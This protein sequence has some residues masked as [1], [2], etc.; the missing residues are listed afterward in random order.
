MK[1]WILYGSVFTA[2]CIV[3]PPLIAFSFGVGIFCVAWYA[4]YRVLMG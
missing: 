3:C 2:C 4:V 1:P